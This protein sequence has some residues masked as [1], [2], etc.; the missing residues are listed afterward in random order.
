MTHVDSRALW[1]A[2]M[3]LSTLWT[4]GYAAFGRSASLCDGEWVR[5]TRSY[6]VGSVEIE[7]MGPSADVWLRLPLPGAVVAW[8]VTGSWGRSGPRWTGASGETLD[9]PMSGGS[10]VLGSPYGAAWPGVASSAIA[11]R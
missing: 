3:R 11:V 6:R 8:L 4:A 7:A 2:V 1:P 5:P 9:W 10:R